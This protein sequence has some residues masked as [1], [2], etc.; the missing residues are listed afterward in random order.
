MVKLNLCK[1]WGFIDLIF[2]LENYFGYFGFY[3]YIYFKVFFFFLSIVILIFDD[4]CIYINF[5]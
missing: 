5:I 4:I 3:G 2:K 1:Y